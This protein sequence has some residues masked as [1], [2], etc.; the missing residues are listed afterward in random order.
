MPRPVSGKTTVYRYKISKKNGYSYVYERTERYDPELKR[1]VKIGGVT[2]LGKVKDDDPE[3]TLL[4][5][6]PKRSASPKKTSK[7]NAI[8]DNTSC[9]ECSRQKT[10]AKFPEPEKPDAAP[11]IEQ[12]LHYRPGVSRIL[13]FIA[14][15][16]GIEK[17]ISSLLDKGT[18]EKLISCVRFLV[19]SGNES[20]SRVSAWQLTHP[21]PFQE[22]LS[23]DICRRLTQELGTDESFREQLFK[24]R[25]YRMP[26]DETLVASLGSAVSSSFENRN[27]AGYGFNEPDNALPAIK[28]LYLYVLGTHEPLA[29]SQ[30]PGSIPDAVSVRNTLEQMKEITGDRKIILVADDGFYRDE[31]A[32]ELIKSGYDFISR[33]SLSA[34]WV[35]ECLERER[36]RLESSSLCA[37]STGC[38]IGIT[39]RTCH[40]F[41]GKAEDGGSPPAVRKI[42]YLHF[43]LD[44]SRR[45]RMSAGFN[46]MLK[47]IRDRLEA[48]CPADSMDP[49]ARKVADDFLEILHDECGDNIRVRYKD[50][51]ISRARADFG[52]FALLTYGA[53]PLLSDAVCVFS[54][55]VRREQIEDRF[56][57]ERYSVDGRHVRSWYGENYM[58]K[59]IMQF[60]VLCYEECLRS[61]IERVKQVLRRDIADFGK[62]GKDPA[63]TGRKQELLTWLN[64]MSIHELLSW[65]DAVENTE[66]SAEIRSAR[67]SP[68]ITERD[69]LF[70]NLLG[71][72]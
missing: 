28:W 64:D 6:R 1:M 58:G 4:K 60:A 72:R 26:Q 69:R 3:Q 61:E 50:E 20:L 11:G 21:I 59:A 54:E 38:V 25:F 51:A 43:Y 68:E 44:M 18:A 48:G 27:S 62:S 63:M 22:G 46:I 8:S 35:R 19:C 45:S 36:H 57:A 10:F 70:F 24:L 49:R 29:F 16:T 56:Q 71:A 14:A 53:S 32:Y 41:Y 17:D 9:Q 2:L 15:K 13:D 31:N 7:S 30:R 5:T 47:G 52:I 40:T 12:A 34:K 23:G 55:Y 42:C 66:V 37:D 39:K 33:A 67:W 65:Y